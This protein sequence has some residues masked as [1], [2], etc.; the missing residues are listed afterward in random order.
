MG[1]RGAN[2]SSRINAIKLTKDLTSAKRNETRLEKIYK[3]KSG[4]ETVFNWNKQISLYRKRKSTKS[5]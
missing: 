2:S 3:G 4:A 5:I 1:G